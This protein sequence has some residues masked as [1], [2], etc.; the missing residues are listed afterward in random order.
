LRLVA[1]MV[2]TVIL[3]VPES[4]VAL[5]V[6]L[7]VR[8]PENV[9]A[10]TTPEALRL[11][12]AMVPTVMFGVPE[13]PVALPVRAP[14]NVVAVTTPEAFRL[15]AAMVPTVILGVPESPVALPVRAP[16]NVV[17]VTTPEALRLVAAMVPT[18]ILGVPERPVA[19]PVTFPTKPPVDVVTPVT[20]RL[21]NVE[22][23][24]V[25][26]P[27][28]LPPPDAVTVT[29]PADTADT[30]KLSPKSMVPAVPTTVPLSLTMTPEPDP[31][32]L[33]S[34]DPSIAGRFPVSCPAGIPVRPIPDP[35]NE[36]AVTTP[37]EF[38]CLTNN[39]GP[40]IVV[41][42]AKVETPVTFRL[43]NVEVPVVSIPAVLPPPPPEALI[44]SPPAVTLL[45]VIFVPAVRRISSVVES[46]PVNLR[47]TLLP[48]ATA[49]CVYVVF[50]SV[51][52]TVTIPAEIADTDRLDPKLI[53]PAVPTV[54]LSSLTI[55]PEPEPT[56]P[57]SPEPS[58]TK[59]VAVTTP[60]AVIPCA[61]KLTV[62]EIPELVTCDKRSSAIYMTY[63]L[64]IYEGNAAA[65]SSFLCDAV[66]TR[67]SS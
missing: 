19:F 67:P 44:V 1:P 49:A 25:L 3:G 66:L 22:V 42:P 18:V 17:A 5:P 45:N 48:S 60:L 62:D 51:P 36:D 29:I 9:V 10:V 57:V 15:V 2:P 59:E 30:V 32:T 24:D 41:I 61:L 63:F 33:I 12:A 50:V 65:A 20:F 16:E 53:V 14:E 27:A 56:T 11:V 55:T 13:R 54:V 7:P 39:V 64:S 46:D 31:I 38:S 47:L 43:V 34:A 8:A 28:I 4:P 35:E 23:P 52:V 37:E 26:I 21:V 6:T 58:P 40:V